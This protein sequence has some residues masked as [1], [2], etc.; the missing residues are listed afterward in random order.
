LLA[1]RL[2]GGPKLE[3]GDT[4]K[5]WEITSL[6]RVFLH[7]VISDSKSNVARSP[8]PTVLHLALHLQHL[9]GPPK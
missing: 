9:P 7:Y 2:D 8:S 4:Q 6:M 1:G 5:N 3:E